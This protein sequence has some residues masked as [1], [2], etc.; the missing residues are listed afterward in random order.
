MNLK[1]DKLLSNFA[2]D[3][4]LRH[5]TMGGFS[6]LLNNAETREVMW[7][8]M[9]AKAVLRQVMNSVPDFGV[10]KAGDQPGGVLDFGEPMARKV[11]RCRLTPV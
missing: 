3:C 10:E 8:A 5:Y 2:F 6:S 11:G 7:A 1:H 4:N 9:K